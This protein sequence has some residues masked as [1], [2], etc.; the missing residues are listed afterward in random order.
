MPETWGYQGFLTADNFTISP[1]HNVP[2]VAGPGLHTFIV[3][4]PKYTSA[5]YE[6]QTVCFVVDTKWVVHVRKPGPA[7]LKFTG[8]NNEKQI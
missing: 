3:E 6:V 5:K 1:W 2:L 8:K 4:I 7:A